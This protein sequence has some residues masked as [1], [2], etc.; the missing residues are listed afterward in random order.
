MADAVTVKRRRI[1]LIFAGVFLGVGLGLCVWLGPIL[2]AAL[3]VGAFEPQMKRDWNGSNTE[4][5]KAL[6]TALSLY[7]QSE[8][9]L[10]DASGW[11]EAIKPYLKTKDISEEDAVNKLRSP[12]VAEENPLAY[13]YAFNKALSGLYFD[14]VENP[15]ETAL[16]FDSSDLS[17]NAHGDPKELVPQPERPG[18][19][20]AITVEGNVVPL[21]DLI[22]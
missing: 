21:N 5:L 16:V 4:N 11:M 20:K 2:N 3:R 8:G 7:E 19:N 15:A 14:E 6:H 1:V 22:K 12:S 13:G 17:F 18:G 9:Q 10:P